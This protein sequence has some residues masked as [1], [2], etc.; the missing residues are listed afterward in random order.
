MAKIQKT[1]P[2]YALLAALGIAALGGFLYVRVRWLSEKNT[3]I[4]LEIA[5]ACLTVF[6]AAFAGTILKTITDLNHR[7]T[8]EEARQRIFKQHVLADL[9]AVHDSMESARLLIEAHKSAKSYGEQIRRLGRSRIRLEAVHRAIK[10]DT[11][12]FQLAGT[13]LIGC[14]CHMIRYIER[15]EREYHDKYL[16]A[17]RMQ[18]LDEE[19]NRLQVLNSKGL[20][21]VAWRGEAW[22]FIDTKFPC[23]TDMRDRKEGYLREFKAPLDAATLELRSQIAKQESG[24]DLRTYEVQGECYKGQL[25]AV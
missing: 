5:K 22:R 16:L 17:S 24:N 8:Q 15:L 11:I 9:K 2:S 1:W 4:N 12:D 6:V 18:K 3:E 19:Y 20:G 14:V 21:D 13:G 7:K 25:V 10:A 23:L